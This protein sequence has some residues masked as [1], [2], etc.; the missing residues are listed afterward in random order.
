MVKRNYVEAGRM[1]L[2]GIADE[3]KRRIKTDTALATV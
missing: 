2:V 1:Q 3:A